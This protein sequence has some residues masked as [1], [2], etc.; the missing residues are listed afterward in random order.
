MRAEEMPLTRM[1]SRKEPLHFLI[2]RQLASAIEHGLWKVG[3]RLP[4]EATLQREFGASRGTVRRAL[5]D[6]EIEG[7]ISRTAG[8]GTF[9]QRTTPRLDKSISEIV[10]FTSQMQQAGLLPTTEV[11]VR[12]RIHASAAGGR[13]AE[14]FGLAP[15]AE[16]FHIQRLRKAGHLPLTIQTVYLRV[17]EFPGLLDHDLAHLFALYQDVYSRRIDRASERFHVRRASPA[18]AALL[19][20]HPG[21]PVLVR[22][23]VTFDDNGQPLEVLHSVDAGGRFDYWHELAGE[24][25]QVVALP[26][27]PTA[28][29]T[30][31]T[32]RETP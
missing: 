3:Q 18:E 25:T 27:L 23:R 9:V 17:D 32:E 20:L 4:S 21:D 29:N 10:S 28:P 5:Y 14:A 31:R 12:A 30:R 15:D 2:K 16:L 8:K 24:R 26:R 11:L 22:D 1:P 19:K 7:Y 6:L 13:A